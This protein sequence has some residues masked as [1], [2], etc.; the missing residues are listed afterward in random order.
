[1]EPVR[2]PQDTANGRWAQTKGGATPQNTCQSARFPPGVPELDRHVVAT[3]DQRAG[4][5][6]TPFEGPHGELV[7]GKLVHAGFGLTDILRE[8]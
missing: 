8:Q 6:R 5:V 4:V 1:M 7:A 2:R 3:G